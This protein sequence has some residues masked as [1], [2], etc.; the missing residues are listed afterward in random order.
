V[1]LLEKWYLDCVTDDG[2][3]LVAYWATMHLGVLRLRYAAC[4]AGRPGAGLTS[5][6][7]LRP[8]APPA[9]AGNELGWN[10]PRLGVA[11]TWSLRES[12]IDRV[13]LDGP[14]GRVRWQCLGPRALATAY[15]GG[16]ALSGTGYVERLTMSVPPWRLPFTSL[17]WGHFHGPGRTLVWIGWRDGLARDWVFDNGVEQPDTSVQGREVSFGSGD[18]LTIDAGMALRTGAIRH[19]ALRPL[20]ALAS[21]IPRWRSARETKWLARARLHTATGPV[22]GWAL[23]EEVSWV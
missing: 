15:V 5:R 16:R 14:R 7:T 23:H 21:V 8:A 2:D 22:Q 20:R 11:G 9:A 13:L 10:C 18:R 4:L 19:T 6:Y 3:V 17:R 12:G 1:F